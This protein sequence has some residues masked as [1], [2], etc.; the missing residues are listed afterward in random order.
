M[1]HTNKKKREDVALKSEECNGKYACIEC[2]GRA[3]PGFVEDVDLAKVYVYCT[4][5][6]GKVMLNCFY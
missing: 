6:V 1:P 4:H 3:Y 2:D 5:L